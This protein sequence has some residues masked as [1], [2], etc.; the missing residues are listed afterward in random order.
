MTRAHKLQALDLI[1]N[2]LTVA[3]DKTIKSVL[4]AA[5]GHPP[6]VHSC[7][8]QLTCARCDAV[9]GDTLTGTNTDNIIILE[10]DNCKTCY[11]IAQSLTLEQKLLVSDLPTSNKK[12]R[13]A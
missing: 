4:C 7:L 8:G 13:K 5:I 9:V 1:N 11:Q 3:S 12:T 6:V 2:A 10:H